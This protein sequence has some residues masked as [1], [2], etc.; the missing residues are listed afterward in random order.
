MSGTTPYE[1]IAEVV[2]NWAKDN[3][4]TDFIVAIRADGEELTEILVGDNGEL[5]VDPDYFNSGRA[6]MR[7][8]DGDQ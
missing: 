5:H 8:N 1:E 2:E 6:E 4:Y 7:R 3:F